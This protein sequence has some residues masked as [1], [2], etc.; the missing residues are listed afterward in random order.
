MMNINERD[1]T[2][3][4]K[5]IDMEEL[6]EFGGAGGDDALQGRIAGVDM[7]ATS[8]D[9]GSDM[10]IR[11]RGTSTINGSAQPLI[12]VDGFPYEATISEDF[13]FSTANEDDYSQLLNIAPS[14]IKEITVLK[15]AAA[16]AIWGSKAAN[17]VLQITTKRGGISPPRIQYSFK[18]QVSHLN[19][20]IP[21]L[22]GSEYITLIQ[23]ELMNSGITFNPS[24]YPELANDANNPY[25]YYKYGQDTVWFKEVA[26]KGFAQE[27]NVSVSGGNTKAQYRASDGYYD[28]TGI[29]IGQSFNRINTRLNVDYYVSDK[30]KFIARMAYTYSKKVLIGRAHV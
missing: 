8:G 19:K 17:G 2:V 13:D 20:G 1:L 6:K 15:D 29:V 3:A 9:P 16:T 5:K 28:Q 24:V 21:T 23:E 11:I 18:G 12:V 22:S 27:H 14:D 30:F 25:Y 26:R 7:V 4:A 10:S